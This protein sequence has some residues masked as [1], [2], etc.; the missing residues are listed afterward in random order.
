M[1]S[2]ESELLTR[3]AALVCHV[4]DTARGELVFAD[5][6]EL[7]VV[8]ARLQATGWLAE[9]DRAALDD[10]ERKGAK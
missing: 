4:A 3:R 6:H 8:E 10:L 1:S 9:Y 2:T 5:K 7:R